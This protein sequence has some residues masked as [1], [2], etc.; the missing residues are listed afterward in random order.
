ML[1]C[2]PLISV[3]WNVKFHELIE[4]SEAVAKRGVFDSL[5]IRD[6]IIVE[7]FEASYRVH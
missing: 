4:A 7:C 2:R 3:V 1:F 5:F 6:N